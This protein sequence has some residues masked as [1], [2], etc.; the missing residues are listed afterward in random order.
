MIL[1]IKLR[2]KFTSLDEQKTSNY[3]PQEENIYPDELEKIAASVPGVITGGV[4]AFGVADPQTG[5]EQCIIV[6]ETEEKNKAA[7]EKMIH[8]IVTKAA[9]A[10]NIKPNPVILVGPHTVPKTSSGKVQRS[11]CKQVYLQ[12]RLIRRKK[13]RWLQF[14]NLI[15]SSVKNKIVKGISVAGKFLYTLYAWLM[16]LI[17][18]IPVGV[19]IQF[20]SVT[21]FNV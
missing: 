18:V 9:S 15:F 12:N 21:L 13:Q 2:V 14:T 17:T 4:A 16:V 7:R 11:Q 8:A 19:L 6:V 20:S 5:T 1:P 10:L 3:F